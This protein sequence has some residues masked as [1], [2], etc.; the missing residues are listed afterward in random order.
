MT[1]KIRAV[2]MYGVKL[3]VAG[4]ADLRLA[5]DLD[6]P[7]EGHQDGVLLEADEVVEQRRDDAPHG[8]RQDHEAEGLEVAQAERPRRGTL[9]RVDRVDAGAVDLGDVGRVDAG[10][11]RGSP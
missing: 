11:G 10:P 3:K 9:A 4:L 7:D 2:A 8:L 6:D 1:M 5:E